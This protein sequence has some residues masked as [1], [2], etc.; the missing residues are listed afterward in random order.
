MV[1]K[2]ITEEELIWKY[3]QQLTGLTAPIEQGQ[4]VTMMEVWYG[5]ICLAKTELVAMNRVTVPTPLTEDRIT[6]D[7][8][9]EQE[10]GK[11]VAMI[12]GFLLILAILVMAGWVLVRVIR[13][14]VL[15]ARV[16]RR[17]R[18]RRRNRNA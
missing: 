14:A 3:E 18:N 2:G 1:P 17:R 9:A 6:G 7:E 15:K 8:L 4:F 5:D 16:R 10:H 11:V 13:R 12:L